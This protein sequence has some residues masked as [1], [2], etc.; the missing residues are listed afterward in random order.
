MN[1]NFEAEKSFI[2]Y[3]FIIEGESRSNIYDI[4]QKK[5]SEKPAERKVGSG[6]PAKKMNGKAVKRLVNSINHKDGV[7]QRRLAQVFKC[8]QPHIC[9]TI[10][11]KT[12][13][14]YRKKT[15]APKRT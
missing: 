4:F 2:A 3:H 14:Q 7:S 10:K 5:K 1:L 15:K 12:K 11:N 9:K 8:S 6:R 13:I